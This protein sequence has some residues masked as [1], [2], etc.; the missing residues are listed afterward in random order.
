MKHIF[1]KMDYRHTL[2]VPGMGSVNYA[3]VVG[4]TNGSTMEPPLRGRQNGRLADPLVIFKNKHTNYPIMNMLNNI[5]GVS[6][7]N[8]PRSWTDNNVFLQ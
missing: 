8:Q 6:Y 1:F 5:E 2:G 4:G 7:R 3:D